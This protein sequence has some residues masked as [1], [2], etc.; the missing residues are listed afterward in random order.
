MVEDLRKQVVS[1]KNKKRGSKHVSKLKSMVIDAGGEI[2]ADEN[3]GQNLGD[4][5]DDDNNPNEKEENKINMPQIP[6]MNINQENENNQ[7]Q[8][9][10]NINNE[11][12]NKNFHFP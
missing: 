12:N 8:I 7:Q 5:L 2:I 4:L 11:I 3:E 6:A 10:A 1:S 9:P